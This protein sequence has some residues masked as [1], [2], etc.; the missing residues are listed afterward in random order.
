MNCD[1]DAN[2]QFCGSMDVKGFP[3]LKIVRPRKGGG[4]PTVE[5]YNGARTATGIVE[6][7]VDRI[8]N[9]VQK[10]T[11]KDLDKFLSEKNESPKA[12]LFTDKGTTSALMKSIAI[13]F[14]DVITVGQ[15]R[16]KETK[17]VE[18]FGIEKFPTLVLLPGGD[19]EAVVYDGE[20]KKPAIVKFL[21][22]AG[23]PNPDPAPVTAKPKKKK[24]S[25]PKSETAT[26]EEPAAP[27]ESAQTQQAPVIVD[28]VTPIPAINTAEK[29]VKECLSEKSS[30]CVL[31]FVPST[32]G[33]GAKEAL[34]SLSTLAH[35]YAQGNHK[36]FP[37]YEVAKENQAAA[38]LISSLE[39][40]G[41]VEL[42]AI[43]AR[44]GWWRRFEGPDFSHESVASW[45]D[46]IRMSEGAKNKLPEGVIGMAFEESKAE[47][48]PEASAE[49]ASDTTESN[50]TEEAETV[51]PEP[52]ESSDTSESTET[53]PTDP[54]AEPETAAEEDAAQQPI[55]HEEL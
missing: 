35:R 2:K 13:D 19:K 7:V 8:N 4:K 34:D 38:S 32:H 42:V 48:A 20:L 23:E 18:T 26:S 27:S 14:L 31:A 44:R 36:L 25:P 17:A 6:A 5:D 1:D 3:T 51:T 43:N 45:I 28:S 49:A 16:D 39:L 41:E 40:S 29:L 46:A 15:V 22:Q 11:D 33:E 50:A 54:T 10:V 37:I 30:T 24:S 52:S 55:K 47:P 9:H 21:S 53:K 12:I